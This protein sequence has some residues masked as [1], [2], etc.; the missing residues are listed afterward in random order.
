MSDFAPPKVQSLLELIGNTPLLKLNKI[1]EIAGN[2]IF[3]KMELM[4]PSGSIKDRVVLKIIEKAEESKFLK[5]N[6][7]I[8]EATTGNTGISLAMIASLKNY[9]AVV[10]VP[11][12]ISKEKVEM[13]KSFG[14][15]VVKVRA[16][17]E[18]VLEKAK[19]FSEE[20]KAFFLNQ[21]E[22][23]ENV[24][25][26][27]KTGEEIYRQM[28]RKID[29]FIAG[30]GT[31]GSLIGIAKFL[32]EKIPEIKV[33]AVE[34]KESPAL[35][36]KFYGKKMKIGN[37]SIEGIGEGFVPKIVEKNLELIDEVV[38]VSSK[39]AMK[40]MKF[41]AREE[42]IFAG[43]SSGANVFAS[44]KVSKKLRN[45]NIVTLLPDRGERYFSK[46][47]FK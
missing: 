33:I 11:A 23:D 46:G 21:F 38:L 40:M 1:S 15:K 3:A 22:R 10:F 41:L 18:K 27:I 2:Q 24:E 34:P 28:Q 20:K 9:K 8:V 13:I 36:S 43:I 39:E 14:A 7:L 4:N 30:I 16:I 6:S 25:A 42:G 35:Y 45:K 47:V 31:G 12:E 26:N 44:L 29:F 17:M 5:K 19:K 37:H 32:K